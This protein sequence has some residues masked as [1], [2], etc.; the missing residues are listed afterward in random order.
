MAVRSVSGLLRRGRSPGVLVLLL[1]VLAGCGSP[2]SPTAPAATSTKAISPAR[3]TAAQDLL[4]CPEW[5]TTESDGY[6]QHFTFLAD[7]FVNY[8][9]K[10]PGEG[11]FRTYAGSS[12]NSRWAVS[13]RTVTITL[14]DGYSTYVA[15][16][17]S[18][19]LA[20]G[21]GHGRNVSDDTWTWRA[22]CGA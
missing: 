4:R 6:V 22:A 2:K 12:D 1:G 10:E 14:N 17:G 9:T 5:T 19:T 13:G 21:T 7:G 20:N 18:T 3:A 11:A 8:G 16:V 15:T